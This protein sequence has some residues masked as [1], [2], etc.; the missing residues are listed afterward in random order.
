MQQRCSMEAVLK[1]T[2]LALKISHIVLPNTHFPEISMLALKGITRIAT[3]R[4]ANARDTMKKLVIPLRRS[5]LKTLLMTRTFPKIAPT[6]MAAIAIARRIS[7][8]ASREFS[9]GCSSSASTSG[10]DRLSGVIFPPLYSFIL[11]M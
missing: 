1:S 7:A 11:R 9:S 10:K 5:N 6:M 3:N 2:S 4:S 8:M